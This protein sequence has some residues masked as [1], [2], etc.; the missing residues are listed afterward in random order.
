MVCSVRWYNLVTQTYVRA[1]SS[2]L[3][4]GVCLLYGHGVH[5]AVNEPTVWS[6]E[7]KTTL[8]SARVPDRGKERSCEIA[9]QAPMGLC[10]VPRLLYPWAFAQCQDSW[11][12]G[13]LLSARAIALLHVPAY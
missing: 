11:T 12:H 13:P 7:L 4:L 5:F 2:P 3:S 1:C 8:T 10:T 9:E 6:I